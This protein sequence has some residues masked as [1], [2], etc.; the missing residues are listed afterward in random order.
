M[1][2]A[3]FSRYVMCFFRSVKIVSRCS[4]FGLNSKSVDKVG[5]M[6]FSCFTFGLGILKELLIEGFFSS[7]FL[8]G[9]ER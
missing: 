6:G 2:L 1:L 7:T 5:F 4:I 9:I 8:F 3:L